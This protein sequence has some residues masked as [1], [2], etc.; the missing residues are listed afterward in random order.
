MDYCV[1]YSCD[2]E[3]TADDGAKLREEVEEG[4]LGLANH[5]FDW[6]NVVEKEDTCWGK[7]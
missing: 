6:G 3:H 1:N 5:Y 2:G 7:V 4:L